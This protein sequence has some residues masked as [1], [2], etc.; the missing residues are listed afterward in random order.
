MDIGRPRKCGDAQSRT[1]GSAGAHMLWS[2]PMA[3]M[4]CAARR[5]DFNQRF[6]S[7]L[8]FY[9]DLSFVLVF[10]GSNLLPR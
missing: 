8:A 9:R 1:S 10:Y 2:G 3:V 4:A 7:A 5:I 6:T